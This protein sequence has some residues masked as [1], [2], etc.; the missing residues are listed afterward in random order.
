VCVC[1]CVWHTCTFVDGVDSILTSVQSSTARSASAASTAANVD[2]TAD[3]A[4]TL[5]T[6]QGGTSSTAVSKSSADTA[7][8]PDSTQ[9]V[10]GATSTQGGTSSILAQLSYAQPSIELLRRRRDADIVTGSDTS[11]VATSTQGPTHLLSSATQAALAA[12]ASTP[13]R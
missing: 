12:L 10:A 2:S 7:T 11:T 3:V 5:S 6:T 8:N 1:V 13:R 4:M 9:D